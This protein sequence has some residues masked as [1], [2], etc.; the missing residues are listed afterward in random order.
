MKITTMAVWNFQNT[1]ST[2]AELG[3]YHHM[4]I[5]QTRGHHNYC[6]NRHLVNTMTTNQ[7]TYVTVLTKVT[8]LHEY[9]HLAGMH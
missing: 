4:A 3:K 1:M 2:M 9:H 5:P 7:E 8:D 6:H